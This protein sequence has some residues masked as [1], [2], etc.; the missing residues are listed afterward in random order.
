MSDE[1]DIEVVYVH[2]QRPNKCPKNIH[3]FIMS[4]LGLPSFNDDLDANMLKRVLAKYEVEATDSQ[5]NDM[6]ALAKEKGLLYIIDECKKPSESTKN[7]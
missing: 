1:S 5:K 3:E 4:E 2:D 7:A 6:I